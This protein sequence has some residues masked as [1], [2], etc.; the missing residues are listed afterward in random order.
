MRGAGFATP[1]SGPW[2][3]YTERGLSLF[4]YAGLFPF[5]LYLYGDLDWGWH[6]RYGEYLVTHGRVLRR[7][8]FS[9][10]MEGYV[11]TNHSWLYDPLLYVIYTRFSFLGLSVAGALVGLGA[12]AIGI[13][14]FRLSYWQKAVLA[15]VFATLTSGALVQGLRSQ[16]VGLL[17]LSILMLLLFHLREGRTWS[18]VALPALFLT[19]ANAHGSFVLGLVIFFI[20][21]V[22]ES[23]PLTRTTP[24]GRQRAPLYALASFLAS[25]AATFAN[26]FTAGVYL[27]ALAHFQSPLVLQR[28]VV[29]WKPEELSGPR[30]IVFVLYTLGLAVGFARRRSRSDVPWVATALALLYLALGSRRYIP[31]YMVGTLPFAAMMIKDVSLPRARY[32]IAALGVVAI[33]ALALEIG[34]LHRFADRRQFLEYSMAS[35][36]AYGPRCSEG[37]TRYL[38]DHPPRGR[39][40]NVYDWGGY[41]IGRGVDAQLFIDGRMHVW[42]RDGYRPIV[43]YARM[44]GMGTDPQM[45]F[46]DYRFDWA[47]V[48]RGHIIDRALE[49]S[50]DWERRYGD[51]IA[52][53]YVRRE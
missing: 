47:I 9:W 31:V 27:E 35:Y 10:T 17:L 32:R 11:W 53:Y 16:V 48:Q 19:W 8:I 37:L 4:V 52:S 26:P 45:F 14:F 43:D 30:G 33:I 25:L 7:D 29:E 6:L 34:V 36:C 21:L 2:A 18:G 28:Y 46:R 15:G 44:Y 12:F 38:L 3:V 40:F 42:E 1:P 5:L 41:L 20:V 39:G 22:G 50:P 49:R 13:W 24:G 51:R 23:V